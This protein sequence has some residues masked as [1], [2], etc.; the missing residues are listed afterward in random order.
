MVSKKSIEIEKKS[1]EGLPYNINASGVVSYAANNVL[2]GQKKDY[3]KLIKTKLSLISHLL[4]AD[5][6]T[7]LADLFKSPDVY[8]YTSSGW[9]PVSISNNNY[10]YRTYLN[11]RV[12]P[13]QFD[14]EFTGNYNSQFL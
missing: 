5:E 4:N 8:L 1:F 11:S 12:T 13:L 10:E 7:W 6:Y 2:Y 9:M 14:V 3:S